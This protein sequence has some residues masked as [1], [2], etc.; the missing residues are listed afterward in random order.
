MSNHG[1]GVEKYYIRH[2]KTN[3]SLEDKSREE[4]SS[5]PKGIVCLHQR[6]F[7]SGR[8]KYVYISHDASFALLFFSQVKGQASQGVLSF[9]AVKKFFCW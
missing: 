7:G 6:Q 1:S 3:V 8:Q 2:G 5:A 4:K 9:S